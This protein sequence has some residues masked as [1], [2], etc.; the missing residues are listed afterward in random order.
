MLGPHRYSWSRGR[1]S[2]EAWNKLFAEM[3]ELPACAPIDL[4]E[5]RADQLNVVS[6]RGE[7]NRLMG[8]LW[9]A[10]KAS[11]DA[12]DFSERAAPSIHAC[13]GWDAFQ[14]AG[15]VTADSDERSE[16]GRSSAPRAAGIGL[17]IEECDS[18][19]P[20]AKYRE[21]AE[22]ASSMEQIT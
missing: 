10:A 4:A 13:R 14:V 8:Q 1:A 16:F 5:L 20:R 18:M 17:T 19:G 22:G 15:A 21:V 6:D 3:S 7:S 12:E 2:G 9:R 11:G